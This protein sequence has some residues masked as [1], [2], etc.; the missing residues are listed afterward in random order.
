MLWGWTRCVSVVIYLL[1]SS[2]LSPSTS[3]EIKIFKS[4][5]PHE[6]IAYAYVSIHTKFYLNPI[7]QKC[8]RLRNAICLTKKIS[9]NFCFSCF[10]CFLWRWSGTYFCIFLS[11]ATLLR[12]SDWRKKRLCNLNFAAQIF[13]SKFVIDQK[14]RH[15]K[16]LLAV[17]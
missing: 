11:P 10:F 4:L 6:W 17:S 3:A 8:E 2:Q 13:S 14:L 15:F 9:P 7:H 12:T 16:V 5:K 1:S